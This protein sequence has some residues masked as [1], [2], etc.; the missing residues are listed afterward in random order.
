MA[1]LPVPVL[2]V[3]VLPVSVLLVPVLAAPVLAA[4]GRR[5][6]PR[7]VI[8]GR[9]SLPGR[10]RATTGDPSGSASAAGWPRPACH[11]APAAL[12]GSPSLRCL[13]VADCLPV[14]RGLPVADTTVAGESPLRSA[15]AAAPALRAGRS[16]KARRR[17]SKSRSGIWCTPAIACQAARLRLFIFIVTCRN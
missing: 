16:R 14:A 3:P 2:L 4:P 7:L 17:L 9:H 6:L 1:A 12:S 15:Q 8:S 10:G 11:A 13:P 5:V